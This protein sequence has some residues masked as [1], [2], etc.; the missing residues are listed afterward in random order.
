[1]ENITS[2]QQNSANPSNQNTQKPPIKIK[3]PKLSWKE[4]QE[5]IKKIETLLDSK[6]LVYYTSNT[7]SISYTH[8]DF[9]ME[10][11]KEIGR[12]DKL[13]L[14]L[15][16]NGGDSTG[17]LRIGT[18]LRDYCKELHIIAPSN[19]ASAA[20]ILALSA[21]KIVMSPLGY[22]TAIDVSVTHPL[23]PRGVNGLPVSISADQIK[24]VIRFLKSENC[25]QEGSYQTLFK[26]VHP[27]AVGEMNR[28]SSSSEL[29]ALK[30]MKLHPQSFEGG[31]EQMKSIASH[32][33]NDYPFHGF[34]I[35]FNEAQEMKLPVEKADN[36]LNELLWE[37]VKTY[38]VASRQSLTNFS[39][40]HYHLEEFPIIIE[41]LNKRTMYRV[42]FNRLIN[43]FK[44]W[45]MMNDNSGWVNLIPS[46]EDD[47]PIMEPVD[48]V[49]KPQTEV[50]SQSQPSSPSEN[51]D[52]SFKKE[53]PDEEEKQ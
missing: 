20:T 18:L 4:S 53:Q 32:L 45:V 29:I 9:F 14:I 52:Y 51:N 42:S 27:V 41:S 19:C 21:D 48:Y 15:I 37:M 30:M 7:S 50:P 23:N 26:Y 46:Q 38:S 40:D 36:N 39:V 6:V 2:N 24:R 17:S 28:M 5:L 34:P 49:N 11:L 47:K 10:H 43:P 25:I 44:L 35:L 8:A 31:E 22:L 1:M 3:V 16:S 13:T 33:V 12:Q